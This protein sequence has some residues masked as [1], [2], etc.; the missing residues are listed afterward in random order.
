M[1]EKKAEISKELKK[2]V[3]WRLETVPPN[4]KL[5]IGTIG[6]FTKEELKQHVEQGDEVGRLFANMQLNF[7]KAIASGAFSK[8]LAE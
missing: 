2:I 3:L 4:F 5:A 7:M 1:N 6:S 8:A